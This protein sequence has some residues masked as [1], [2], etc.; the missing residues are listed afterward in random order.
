MKVKSCCLILVISGGTLSSDILSMATYN[1]RKKALQYF[2]P[3]LVNALVQASECW[4]NLVQLNVQVSLDLSQLNLDIRMSATP[5]LGFRA[6]INLRN[7]QKLNLPSIGGKFGVH[8]HQDIFP[9]LSDR[10]HGLRHVG[11]K[12]DDVSML[13]CQI[14]Q[15]SGVTLQDRGVNEDNTKI[16]ANQ[17]A[18]KAQKKDSILTIIRDFKLN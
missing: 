6:S 9:C 8:F 2:D 1:Q 17:F 10:L 12:T 5:R 11:E 13:C 7:Q 16:R 3:Q 14:F 15:L 4:N 18:R